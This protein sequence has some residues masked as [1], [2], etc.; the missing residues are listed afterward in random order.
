MPQL[1]SAL[2]LM[3]R[4]G[5]SSNDGALLSAAEKL[6]SVTTY[7]NRQPSI[8][9]TLLRLPITGRSSSLY[10]HFLLNHSQ[11]IVGERLRT[12]LP[13]SPYQSKASTI[14]MSRLELS[15][16]SQCITAIA[17]AFKSQAASD[18]RWQSPKGRA[19]RSDILASY[20][21]VAMPGTPTPIC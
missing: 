5:A 21:A 3:N 9:S 14:T 4:P 1:N 20:H 16:K 7:R 19:R 10:L 15:Q 13:V 17:L 2:Q 12:R 8:F 6:V 18:C 11:M